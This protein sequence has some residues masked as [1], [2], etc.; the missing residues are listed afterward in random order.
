MKRKDLVN[1]VKNK[2]TSNQRVGLLNIVFKDQFLNDVDHVIVFE[3]INQLLPEHI[4]N[5]VEIIYI[6]DFGEFKERD[7]DAMY[8]DGAIY[9]SNNNGDENNLIKDII[10]E[11]AHATEDGFGETVYADGTIEQNFLS[12]REKIN[13]FINY[14]KQSLSRPEY[15]ENLDSFLK[16][17]V[18][19]EKINNLS[20]GLFLG[21]YSITSLR[22]YFARGFEEY[23]LGDRDYLKKICP[24]IYIKL[25]LIEDNNIGE[26]NYEF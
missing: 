23:Y 15:D 11:F 13:A 4:L 2:K 21:A 1:Y 8:S 10:H 14:E 12:K 24:Y 17:E 25:S 7:I 18:G 20:R 9:I 3:K 5:L 19:Y 22:E 26:N 16:D 6:G